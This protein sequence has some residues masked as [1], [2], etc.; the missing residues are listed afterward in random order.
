MNIYLPEMKMQHY[1]EI[2]N[3][4]NKNKCT[5]SPADLYI[6]YE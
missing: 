2:L 3:K 6:S 1:G 5:I 4:M